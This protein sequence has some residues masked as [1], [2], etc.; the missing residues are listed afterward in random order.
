MTYKTVGQFKSKEEAL[1]EA[2]RLAKESHG[3]GV[4]DPPHYLL[5]KGG[6]E[7]LRVG[8]NDG[9]GVFTIL[10]GPVSEWFKQES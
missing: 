5:L 2:D 9:K 3:G 6:V 4:I 8:G 10:Q 1:L 7:C